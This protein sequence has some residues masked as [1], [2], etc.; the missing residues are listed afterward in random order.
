MFD[1]VERADFENQSKKGVDKM[2][3]IAMKKLLRKKY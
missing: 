1:S 2:S 3:S